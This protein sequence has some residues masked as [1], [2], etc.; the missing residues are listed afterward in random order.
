MKTIYYSQH[1]KH[2]IKAQVIC[3]AMQ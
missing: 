3:G 1:N 2:T